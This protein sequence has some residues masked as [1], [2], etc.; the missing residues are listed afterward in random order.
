[1]IPA[2]GL[3]ERGRVVAMEQKPP[4]ATIAAANLAHRDG[5]PFQDTR[6]FEDADRGFLGRLEPCVVT[7]A[8]G[9]VVW[10]NDSYGFLAGDAPDPGFAIITP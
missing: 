8:D 2:R 10:D 9:R 5:L 7:A 1:V 4:T 3:V 6:D